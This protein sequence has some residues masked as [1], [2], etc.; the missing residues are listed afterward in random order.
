MFPKIGD[1]GLSKEIKDDSEHARSDSNVGSPAFMAPEIFE[2]FEYSKAGDVY[3]FSILLYEIT[4]FDLP[5]EGFNIF[6]L[7]PNVIRGVRPVFNIDIHECY[8]KLIEK[9]WQQ[10]PEKRPTFN[11]IVELLRNDEEFLTDEVDEDEFFK[12]VKFVDDNILDDSFKQVE[13]DIKELKR[14]QESDPLLNVPYIDI[15]LF[16]KL[17]LIKKI[18]NFDIF[19]VKNN[20]T[21]EHFEAKVSTFRITKLSRKEIIHLSRE[22]NIL[23]KLIHPSFLK[24]IGFSPIDF[25]KHPLPVLVSELPPN[26]SLEHLLNKERSDDHVEEWND[27]KRLIC[28]Y[29]IACGMSFLHLHDIL[30]RNLC[31]ES[32]FFDEF[33]FPKIGNFGLLTKIHAIESMTFQSSIGVKGTPSHSSPELLESGEYSK[34]SDVYAFALIVFELMTLEVPFKNINTINGLYNEVVT[35]GKRPQFNVNVAESY[36]RLIE[37]CWSQN[38]LERP[39]FDDIESCLKTDE[40]FITEN[41]DKETFNQYVKLIEQSRKVFYSNNRVVRYDD[42]IEGKSSSKDTDETQKDTTQNKDDEA[43]SVDRSKKQDDSSS[44]SATKSERS[45]TPEIS[46]EVENLIERLSNKEY[47]GKF[48]PDLLDYLLNESDQ[49]ST[50]T[51][52]TTFKFE[53]SETRDDEDSILIKVFSKKKDIDSFKKKQE[54]LKKCQKFIIEYKK[55]NKLNHPNISKALGFFEGDKKKHQPSIIFPFYSRSLKD[56]IQTLEDV[57]LVSIIY[58][59]TH[60]MMTAHSNKIIHRN[61]NPENIFIDFENHVK[62]TGFGIPILMDTKEQAN[63]NYNVFCLPKEILESKEYNE[64]VDV[65][66]FGVIMLFILTRGKGPFWSIDDIKMEQ[67]TKIPTYI[68]KTSSIIISQCLS[69]SQDKRPTFNQIKKY[70]VKNNFKLIDG[71]DSKVQFIQDHLRSN[72]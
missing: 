29:G 44:K 58:E 8:R 11:E 61:L 46:D 72:H 7:P 2:R 65:F 34:S 16:E 43:E 53:C 10:E 36:R 33:L 55:V 19:E 26:K 66:S 68:S 64:K 38:P 56:A 39:S 45:I 57:Y 31:P 32:I 12:Y 13:V 5:Y 49:I 67:I 18:D 37:S 30:H 63:L 50:S 71:I 70:I 41:V 20:E 59:I 9:C 60:A 21:N 69:H 25:D 62:I 3:A 54:E 15:K 1:F 22:I 6:N 17:H 52:F 23:S 51:I 24:F 40:G 14:I 42:L 47:I 28:I 27:T 48:G 4:T 35:L